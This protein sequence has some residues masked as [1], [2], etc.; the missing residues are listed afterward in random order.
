[1]SRTQREQRTQSAEAQSAEAQRL[2]PTFLRSAAAF[3]AIGVVLY[4]GL[5]AVAEWLVYRHGDR[6]RFFMVR[7]V[8]ATTFD[9]VVLGA[10]H[11]AVFD[12]GD[13]NARLEAL[14]GKRI[15][16][17]SV[18]GGGIVVNRLLLDYFQTRHRTAAILYVVDSFAFYS[19]EWNEERLEDARLFHRAPFDLA[20]AGLLARSGAAWRVPLDYVTGF[21]KIN[22][23]DRFAPDVPAE[24]S[25]FD[26]RYRPIEQLDRQRIDYLYPSEIDERVRATRQRYFSEFEALVAAARERGSRVVLL[27]PPLP[28]RTRALIPG[29]D[30]FDAAFRD[31]AA[32]AGAELHD[33]SGVADDPAL[34]FDSDHL[35]RTGVLQ[36]YDRHL[37]GILDQRSS[38]GK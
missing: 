34:Y 16:N 32:R 27:R 22:N 28:P 31:L 2:R 21:S 19:R 23:A 30:E 12:F 11:A 29:E 33:L 5:F 20:L 17:L 38:E 8:P 36:L 13:M 26:R 18:V 7:T 9:V 4:L 24:A 37:G 35:N 14:T 10:S 6:N 25:R 1:M 3:V 15:L